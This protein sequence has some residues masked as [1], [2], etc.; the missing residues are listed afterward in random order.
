MSTAV[1][2]DDDYILSS[3]AVV[4]IDNDDNIFSS[5]AEAAVDIRMPQQQEE[6]ERQ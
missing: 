6:V 3:E 5:S 2:I 4:A 1:A